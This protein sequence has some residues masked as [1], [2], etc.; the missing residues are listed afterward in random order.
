MGD[1]SHNLP[2]GIWRQPAMRDAARIRDI[3][4]VYRLLT[5]AGIPQRRI[6]A[7]TG[8]SQSEVSEILAGRR[9][10]SYVVL[11][12]IADGLGAPRG[13]LG[14]GYDE[15]TATTY[16]DRQRPVPVE[17]VTEAMRRRAFLNAVAATVVGSPVLGEVLELPEPSSS[18]TPLPSRV[19]ASDVAALR[20]LTDRLAEVARTWGGYSDGLTPVATHAERLLTVPAAA[21]VRRD[22]VTSVAELHTIAGWAGFDAHRDDHARY[23]FGRAVK[24]STANGDPYATAY[25]LYLAGVVNEERGDPDNAL[26]LFQLGRFRLGDARGDERAPALEAWLRADSAGAL[27]NMGRRD[28]AGA[29]LATAR[30]VWQPVGGDDAAELDF[31]SA[32]VQHGLGRLDSAEQLAASAVRHRQHT[33]DRRAAV[34]ERITWA[35]LH[36]TAGEPSGASMAERVIGDVAELRSQRARDRLAP[37][38]DDLD[39]RKHRELAGHARRVAATGL[40]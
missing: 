17:E 6:A 38:A 25:A 31:V 21:D 15:H 33:A 18:P 16:A 9:V 37:L 5:E 36:V 14:L 34:V 35:Q 26:K 11:V 3:P 12:R 39:A 27:V 10:L 1:P 7:L 13:L 22:L 29:E 20:D 19:G 23:H 8:Q 28:D 4:A 32:L 40:G 24:L 2:S 30:G